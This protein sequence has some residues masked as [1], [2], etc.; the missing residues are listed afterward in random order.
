MNI[1]RIETNT[2]RRIVTAMIANSTVCGRIS[3]RWEKQLFKSKYANLIAGWCKKYYDAY[4]KCPGR[5]ITASYEAW[6]AK[7]NRDEALMEL[8]ANYLTNLSED[9]K[10]IK[11]DINPQLVLDEAGIFFS[12]VKLQ[13][14][15]DELEQRLID[16]DVTGGIDEIAKFGTVQLTGNED[17][18]IFADDSVLDE[19]L[20]E[21]QEPLI[22][23]PGALGSF[24]GNCFCRGAFVCYLA[25]AKRGKT[26]ML[27]DVAVTGVEQG[28]RVGI[29]GAGDMSRPQ[30]MGRLAARVAERPVKHNARKPKYRV[31]TQLHAQLN[32]DNI[33]E[34][35]Y[36]E[37]ETERDMTSEELKSV[38]AEMRARYGITKNDP[39]LRMSTH[40]SGTLS[41]AGIQ[42]VLKRWRESGFEPDVL[43]LDYADLL[44]APSGAGEGRDNINVIWKALRGLAESS[45]MCLVTVT[46]ADAEGAQVDTL[47]R[48]NFSE[49]VRKFNHVTDMVGLNAT[50]KEMKAGVYRLSWIVRREEEEHDPVHVAGC[51]SICRPQ[52]HSA[53]I[54]RNLDDPDV[55]EARRV[56]KRKARSEDY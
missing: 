3:S 44:I 49:D 23:F 31:P 37:R 46:Q 6:A 8:V 42:T 24:Y 38:F 30:Y 43:I 20:T 47:S 48:S 18:D 45:H 9:Y 27:L 28:R 4:E 19:M 26:F 34:I 53:L 16:G 55:D 7:G 52:M 39:R 54:V 21:I 40:P 33:P 1:T 15:R 36:E 51:K 35:D 14:L 10:N 50:T 13:R 17:A 41:V 56:T 12:R 25:P 32:G 29:I 2:E 5:D 11:R 22:V